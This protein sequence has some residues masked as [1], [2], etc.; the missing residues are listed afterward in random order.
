MIILYPLENYDGF[1]TASDCTSYLTLNVP[2]SQLVD[3]LLL[4]EPSVEILIRQATTL[5]K[6]KI[7]LPSTLEDN[8]KNACAYLVKYSVTNVMTNSDTEGNIKV[9][10]VVGVVKTEYFS[11]NQANNSFPDIVDSLLSSYGIVQDGTISFLR[12]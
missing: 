3:Y 9:D 8:L 11:P 4:D 5:I 10:E 1:I 6:S 7:T 2:S 12:G